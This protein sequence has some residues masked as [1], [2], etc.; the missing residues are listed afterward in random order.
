[1]EKEFAYFREE[2]RFKQAWLWLI[3][4]VPV[5]CCWFGAYV[6][7]ILKKPFGNNPAPDWLLT[8]LWVVFGIFLPL[9]FYSVKLE[10]EVRRDGIFLRFYPFHIKYR[11]MPFEEIT[12]YEVV[13]YS[14]FREYGGWGI[15]YGKSGKAYNVSGNRGVQLALKSGRRILLGSQKPEQLAE[16]IR[17]ASG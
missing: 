15:R 2:Q 17:S 3:I 13:K 12:S 10:T 7:L 5:A 4:L 14:P 1:M 8:I 16:A 9:F 11:M 6:Q